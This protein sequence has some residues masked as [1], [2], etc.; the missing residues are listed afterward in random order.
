MAGTRPFE[1]CGED[2]R[3]SLDLAAVTPGPEGSVFVAATNGIALSV[4]RTEGAAD[5]VDFVSRDLFDVGVYG[6]SAVLRDGRWTYGK[7]HACDEPTAEQINYPKIDHVIPCVPDGYTAVSFKARELLNI[8]KAIC[9]DGKTDV[10]LLIHSA[11]PNAIPVMGDCGFG[12]LATND[13]DGEQAFI[14]NRYD[15]LSTQFKKGFS[16]YFSGV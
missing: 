1:C 2:G 16:D 15:T 7:K 11:N 4:V 10:T 14:A 6:C 12:V 9:F 3:Y 8:A 13:I 5:A